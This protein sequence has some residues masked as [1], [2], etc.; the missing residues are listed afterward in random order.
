MRHSEIEF[1]LIEIVF[2]RAAR[3]IYLSYYAVRPHM[4]KQ[5][6][7]VVINRSTYRGK[8]LFSS[9]PILLPEECFVPL[10]Q[11]ESEIY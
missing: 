9:K 2:L 7:G 3:Q 1:A 10:S 11:I 8:L 4:V 6:S 5:P